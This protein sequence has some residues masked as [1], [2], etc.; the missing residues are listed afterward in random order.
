[1]ARGIKKSNVRRANQTMLFAVVQPVASATCT[2]YPLQ[3]VCFHPD[4]F[5]DTLIPTHQ[6]HYI[7]NL[8]V[9]KPCMKYKR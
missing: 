1:M 3:L 8:F 9:I 4:Q 6:H 2:N 5:I 7:H